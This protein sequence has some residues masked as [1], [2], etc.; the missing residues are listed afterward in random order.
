MTPLRAE[1]LAIHAGRTIDPGTRAV[2]QPI[3]LSTTFERGEDGSFPGGYIYTRDANP[4]RRA[5][6]EC[7]NALEGGAGALA[8]SSGMAATMAV[9]QA[10]ESGAH[11]VAPND[12]YYGTAKL[13]RE[14]F[15][16]W[17]LAAT[18]V[19]MADP[20]AVEGALRAETRLVWVETPSN[21]ALR[22]SDIR[23]IAAVAH[24][25]GA[26]V[27]VDNTWATPLL[28]RPLELGAD[29]VMHATT[30]YLS[31]HS[32]VLG[33]AL[34]ARAADD[35]WTRI[36]TIQRTGGAVPSPFD[37]W[38]VLRGIRTLPYRMRAHCANAATIARFLDAHPAVE[39]VH[40]PGLP[41]DPGHA[42][43]AAQMSDFG[44]MLSFRVHGGRAEALAAIARL[45]VITR[46]T[47]L[48]GCESLVEHRA[49]VEGPAT[50]TPENLLRLSVGL[51][52]PDDLLEDLARALG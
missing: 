42:V 37:S 35:F 38:L 45:E 10:L 26:R 32:D 36:D 21:P 51:E 19:D 43:A 49:S 22:I 48:G 7:L 44:G 39:G 31:G 13:L 50:R 5:L 25:A 33:G 9:L 4:N 2:T 6:E 47:S 20:A 8:F 17:G 40:Y 16:R 52:H 28:Q 27:A 14:V 34:V 18:F 23:R 3:H 11:V 12:A 24:A 41:G 46:A 1:T 30:K 29:I 15:A